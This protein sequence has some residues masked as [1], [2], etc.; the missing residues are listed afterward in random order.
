[1][2]IRGIRLNNLIAGYKNQASTLDPSWQFRFAVQGLVLLFNTAVTL[3]TIGGG[4]KTLK[5]TWALVMA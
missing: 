3:V 5:F 2:D 1:M 4:S